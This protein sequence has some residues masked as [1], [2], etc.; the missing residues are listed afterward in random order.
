MDAI[1][2]NIVLDRL[3][4][5]PLV[6]GLGVLGVVLVVLRISV[7]GLQRRSAFYND[8]AKPIKEL[9]ITD[10]RLKLLQRLES[11]WLEHHH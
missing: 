11:I 10:L 4:S 3:L 7:R 1:R 2:G 5:Q 6:L 8:Q 9:K